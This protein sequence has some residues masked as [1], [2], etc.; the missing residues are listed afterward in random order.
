M[1]SMTGFGRG[2]ATIEGFNASVDL[3]TV[4]NRFL[5]VHLRASADL[6]IAEA[7]IRRRISERL[8][9]GRVDAQINIER[10]GAVLYEL[11]R[12][13]IYGYITAIRE[14]QKEFSLTGEPDVNV[15]ARLP[16]AMQTARDS[17]SDHMLNC[18]ERALAG[19]LDELEEMRRREGA[20][21]AAEMRARLDEIERHVPLIEAMAGGQVDAYRARLQRRIS[22]L[23]ARD[24]LEIVELDQGR[25]AQEVAYLADRSDITEEITRLRSHL[26]QFR[27]GVEAE[28]EIGKRL[29]FLLQELNREAN[30]ILSKSTDTAIKESALAIKAAVEKLREQVQNVE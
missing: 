21:L 13:L 6:S 8:S 17:L 1:K 4:N 16:G 14:M 25:L 2:S 23:L 30:T 26:M 3:K 27:D 22:E 19:A 15:L 11:N 29:D 5:D 12:P 18:V 7:L 20:A 9:R 10:T 24:G 28:G